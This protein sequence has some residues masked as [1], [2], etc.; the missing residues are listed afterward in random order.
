[1]NFTEILFY[2]IYG[3]VENKINLI[4][5]TPIF[6]LIEFHINNL[7]HPPSKLSRQKT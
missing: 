1:M 3:E 5:K 7:L 6:A 4:I 2:L